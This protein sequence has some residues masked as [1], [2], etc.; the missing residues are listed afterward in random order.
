[1]STTGAPPAPRFRA[2]L[3]DGVV[4]Q[5]AWCAI[6]APPPATCHTAPRR[7]CLGLVSEHERAV[8]KRYRYL[9]KLRPDLRIDA[10]FPPISTLESRVPTA[11]P[12]L[13]TSF[14]GRGA[15]GASI[16]FTRA[17]GTLGDK[18][19]LMRR[20]VADVYMNA[21]RAFDGQARL[22]TPRT[23]F[24][25][26]REKAATQRCRCAGSPRRT[27]RRLRRPLGAD[28]VQVL[29]PPPLTRVLPH[30]AQCISR[31]AVD[32]ACGVTKKGGK[33]LKPALKGRRL[34]HARRRH[35]PY[36]ATPQCVLG[37]HMVA[38]FDDLHVVGCVDARMTIVRP[39]A[40]RRAARGS[41]P[42]TSVH[43]NLPRG[44]HVT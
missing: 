10:P 14:S 3:D 37:R 6:G 24:C 19:A 5:K 40:R 41:K 18:W 22:C 36:W 34:A 42:Q 39:D 1:M 29:M 35:S 21:T 32:E 9:L 44:G 11:P 26:T 2:R 13:C 4:P 25:G 28:T 16:R 8:A 27:P 38:A 17:G 7:Q 20:D 12:T 15:S 33:A 31:R 43:Q 30:H 23:T